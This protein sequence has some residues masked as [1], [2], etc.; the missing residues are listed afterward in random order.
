[1]TRRLFP[2]VF[3]LAILI[4]LGFYFLQKNVLFGGTLLVAAC[5]TV[6]AFISPSFENFVEENRVSVSS[7]LLVAFGLSG[8]TFYFD[9]EL[10]FALILWAGALLLALLIALEIW[11]EKT[12]G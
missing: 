8:I 9:N 6:L 7:V 2:T 4:P 1:M 3:S 10:Q 12:F 5:L 11:N